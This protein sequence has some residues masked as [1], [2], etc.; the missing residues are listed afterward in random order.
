MGG[1]FAPGNVVAGSVDALRR[2]AAL[3]LLLVGPEDRLRAELS[4]LG[5]GGLPITVVRT[6]DSR[7]KQMGDFGVGWTL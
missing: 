5:A 3:G 7:N 1:D 4:R 6:Y 2:D